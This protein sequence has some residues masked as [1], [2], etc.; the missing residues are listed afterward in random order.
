L[1]ISD[2]EWPAPNLELLN[3]ALKQKGWTG[4][5]L[6]ASNW[7]KAVQNKI[8]S[9]PWE[10][11]LDDVRPFIASQDDFSLLTRDNLLNLLK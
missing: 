2:R 1:S 10:S 3:N 7:R 6:T 4:T 9:T 8:E 5:T 11:A